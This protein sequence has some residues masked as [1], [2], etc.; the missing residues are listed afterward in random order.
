MINNSISFNFNFYCLLPNCLEA[1]H[2][3]VK[4]AKNK[5]K[6]IKLL[7]GPVSVCVRTSVLGFDFTFG[8]RLL[9]LGLEVGKV[10]GGDGADSVVHVVDGV[11]ELEVLALNFLQ[12]FLG[13]AQPLFQF[14]HLILRKKYK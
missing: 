3:K 2:L 1:N 10:G 6:R 8:F 9:L 14:L 4:K 11:H 12:V 5:Y 7:N 13:G